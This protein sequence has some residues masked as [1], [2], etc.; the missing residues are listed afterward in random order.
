MTLFPY[1]YKTKF[2][3][4]VENLVWNI[5]YKFIHIFII[6]SVSYKRKLLL[7]SEFWNKHKQES[8]VLKVERG[9]LMKS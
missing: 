1:I 6:Y 2:H 5:T 3:I 4:R 9:Y 7:N 8:L